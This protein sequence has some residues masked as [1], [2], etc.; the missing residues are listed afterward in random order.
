MP[1][2]FNEAAA[3]SPRKYGGQYELPRIVGEL[4]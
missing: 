1:Q 3:E 2:R 4:Q